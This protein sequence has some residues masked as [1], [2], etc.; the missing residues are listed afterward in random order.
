MPQVMNIDKYASAN[1]WR[2]M[3]EIGYRLG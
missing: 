3:S 1:R 2:P